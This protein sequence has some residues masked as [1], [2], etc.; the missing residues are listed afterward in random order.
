[1]NGT[2]QVKFF[3][4]FPSLPQK[5]ECTQDFFFGK[6]KHLGWNFYDKHFYGDYD[7][8]FLSLKINPGV[9]FFQKKNSAYVPLFEAEKNKK[10]EYR[11]AWFRT[12]YV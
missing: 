6:T 4:F 8:Q 7:R 9:L 10:R 11:L 5:N 3:N 12:Y 2:K 1:M